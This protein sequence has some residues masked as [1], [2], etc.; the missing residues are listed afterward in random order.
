MEKKIFETK[1]LEHLK[2]GFECIVPS[3]SGG[4]LSPVATFGKLIWGVK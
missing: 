3:L 4:N 2:K 1:I